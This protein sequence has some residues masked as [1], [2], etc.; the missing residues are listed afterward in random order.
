[1]PGVFL[2]VFLAILSGFAAALVIV[3]WIV[4]PFYSEQGFSMVENPRAGGSTLDPAVATAIRQRMIAV[5]DTTKKVGGAVYPESSFV[6]H[7]AI[8]SSDGWTVISGDAYRPGREKQWEGLDQAGI[9]HPALRA[10]SDPLAGVV[11]V[12]F[13]GEG[14]RVFS[15]PDWQNI[16]DNMSLWLNAMRGARGDGWR[17]VFLGESSRGASTAAF[18]AVQ[19][20]YRYATEPEAAVGALLVTDRGELAGFADENGRLVPGWFITSQLSAVLSGHAIRYDLAPIEGYFAEGVSGGD[21]VKF[22]SGFYITKSVPSSGLLRG[23]LLLRIGGEAVSREHLSRQMLF[24]PSNASLSVLRAG[25]E[26]EVALRT[27]PSAP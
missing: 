27:A 11:Y 15:F 9:A 20:E 21:A 2:T 12:K 26:R 19:T 8:L 4:P 24:A 18:P 10:V 3:A 5:V 22:L 14:Y 7:A 23:D 17:H 13:A 25:Q 1:M 6:T 16:D